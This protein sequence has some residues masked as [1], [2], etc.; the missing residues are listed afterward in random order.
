MSRKKTKNQDKMILNKVTEKHF[1][2]TI[3]KI[4][5]KLL[6]KFRFGYHDIEDMKQQAYIFALQGLE[7]Y[8]TSKPLEN[9]LWT[10]I[11]NRLFNFKRDKYQRP[12]KPCNSCEYYDPNNIK[13]TSQCSQFSCKTNCSLYNS[14]YT[15]N[16]YKKNLMQI[17]H[18]DNTETIATR[19]NDFINSIQNQEILSKIDPHIKVDLRKYYLMVIYGQ[20]IPKKYN[21]LLLQ[22]I[23][24]ILNDHD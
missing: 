7:N 6:H 9:F 18:T 3:N 24:E 8:D 17:N 1:L 11:R 22:H 21:S 4:C 10:H 19:E 12:D 16:T 13:S 5:Y 23:K 20:K 14:W 2:E 15:K